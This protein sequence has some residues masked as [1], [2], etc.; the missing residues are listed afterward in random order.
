MQCPA[1]RRIWTQMVVVEGLVV[2]VCHEQR[3]F[4]A[5]QDAVLMDVGTG[6][7]DK[8]ARL[9]ITVCIDVEV[10]TSTGDTSANEFTIVLEIHCVDGFATLPST[11]FTDT[12]NHVLTL[13]LGGQ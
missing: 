3:L 1:S 7:V 11:D 12:F 10:V 9:C 8:Y 13:L 2:T 5:L 6:V 4:Q